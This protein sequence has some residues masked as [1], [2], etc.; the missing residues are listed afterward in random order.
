MRLIIQAAG[1]AAAATATASI[2]DGWIYKIL[3]APAE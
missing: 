2:V 3:S 1:A